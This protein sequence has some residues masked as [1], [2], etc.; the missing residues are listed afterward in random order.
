MQQDVADTKRRLDDLLLGIPNLPWQG[1]PVGPNSFA[2]TVVRREGR[3]PAFTYPA[4]NHIELIEQ[5]GPPPSLGLT[6]E[7]IFGLFKIQARPRRMA[8]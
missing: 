2:N 8:A 1:A 6:E 5:N 3:R 4:K 7:E